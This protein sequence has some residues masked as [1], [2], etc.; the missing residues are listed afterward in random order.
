MRIAHR[1]QGAVDKYRQQQPRSFAQLLDVQ[2]AAVL[3]MRV[4]CSASTSSNSNSSSRLACR[5]NRL[6]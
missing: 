4:G 2:V 3:A 1:K 5:K 6:T